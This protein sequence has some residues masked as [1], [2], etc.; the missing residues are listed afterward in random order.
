MEGVAGSTLRNKRY[1][2]KNKQVRDMVRN[3][4]LVKEMRE[5]TE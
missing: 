1:G 5:Y 2:R 4:H 3:E